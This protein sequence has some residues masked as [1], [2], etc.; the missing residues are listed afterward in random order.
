M[1]L[2]AT[3]RTSAV[4]FAFATLVAGC[5]GSYGGAVAPIA[6]GTT[7][8]HTPTPA[9]TG[10]P[11]AAPSGTPSA[12]P[13]PVLTA[14]PTP[15]PTAVPTASPT[16][17]PNP[18]VISVSPGTW[19]FVPFPN[20]HCADGSTTGLAVNP[21]T[22]T[23][24]VIYFEGGGE[25]WDSLTCLTLQTAANTNGY[26]AATFAAEEPSFKGSVLD[27]TLANNPFATANLVYVPYCTGDDHAGNNVAT[28][29][30]NNVSHQFHHV[31][32]AN[33][34]AFLTRIFPT[35]PSPHHL[36][37]TGSDAGG[38]GA[39]F[40]FDTLQKQ[41][42]ATPAYLIDDSGPPLENGIF[43]PPSTL[44]DIFTNWNLGA[45]LDPLCS[46]RNG[47][48]PA[49]AALQTKYPNDR[50]S[51]LSY[52]QDSVIPS[53]YGITASQFE[54]DL[55]ALGSGVITTPNSKYFFVNA[56]GHVLLFNP[57]SLTQGVN[58]VTWLGQQV[59]DS[60]SWASQKP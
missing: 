41:W 28:Y 55:L 31:G 10:S 49:L 25:C 37:V 44:S 46:C 30:A 45:L 52:E 29:V 8:T 12:T 23:D 6:G 53:Y 38:Y 36:I 33:V 7:P 40:D 60:S 22:G 43:N 51:L 34:Q 15:K 27:R 18:S 13:T 57:A 20:S 4:A 26:T 54:T 32:Y 11:T 19:T 9:S 17:T 59:N 5:S 1:R 3:L 2:V 50:L 42:P 58:L 16:P 47:F 14:T 24:L 39:L 21:G 56:Q 35:W 48:S